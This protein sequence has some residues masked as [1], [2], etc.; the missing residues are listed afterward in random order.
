M[1]WLRADKGITS[2][3]FIDQVGVTVGPSTTITGTG[4]TGSWGSSGA[5]S[6]SSIPNG[7]TS[8]FVSFSALETTSFRMA[9]LAANFSGSTFTSID[10]AI[11]LQA[12][13]QVAVFELGTEVFAGG[14]YSSGDTFKVQVT[15]GTVTY[16][17]NGTAFFTSSTPVA[18]NM[19]FACAFNGSGATVAGTVANIVMSPALVAAVS[20]WA[21]QSGNGNSVSQ[22]VSANQPTLLSSSIGGL[23]AL[24]FNASSTGLSMTGLLSATPL[25]I[26]AV[27]QL[28]IENF[29]PFQAITADAAGA[30]HLIF[31]SAANVI[32][33]FENPDTISATANVTQPHAYCS[34]ID[35]ASSAI[36]VDGASTSGTLAAS[37]LSPFNVGSYGNA[38]GF[39]W[40][41]PISEIVVYSVLSTSTVHAVGS[42]LASRYGIPGSW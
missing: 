9:G 19:F 7:S 3:F 15:S 23:P 27:A 18:A 5:Q 41:G 36:Y 1:L 32:D 25:M 42:Y 8:G 24:E 29:A 16:L 17:Q 4:A 35:G 26:F 10:H 13:G 14:S 34:F 38:T 2:S 39:F 20:G 40:G 11:Y 12:N 28:T 22:S 30:N 37:T 21:D 33:A 31:A 6:V